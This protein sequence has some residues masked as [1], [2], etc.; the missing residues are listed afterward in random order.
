M[1]IQFVPYVFYLAMALC[2]L[3]GAFGGKKGALMIYFFFFPIVAVFNVGVNIYVVV[4]YNELYSEFVLVIVAALIPIGFSK[5][6]IRLGGGDIP[7][8]KRK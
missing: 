5:G 7:L 1:G 2:I 8:L 3:I 4:V 6:F